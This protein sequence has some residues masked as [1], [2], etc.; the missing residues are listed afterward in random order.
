VHVLATTPGGTRAAL[1]AG[2]LLARRRRTHIVLL[3]TAPDQ[4]VTAQ[5]VHVAHQFDPAM[6]IRICRG[7]NTTEAVK[8]AVPTLAVV[9]IGGPLRWWWPTVEYRLAERLRRHGRLVVFIPENA[10]CGTRRSGGTTCSPEVIR[11][12]GRRAPFS[13]A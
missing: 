13:H 2:Q 7:P 10:R 1:I 11:F 3:V 12:E 9:V 8:Q 5:C 6:P 4:W